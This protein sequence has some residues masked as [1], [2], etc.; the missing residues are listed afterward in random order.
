MD[1]KRIYIFEDD[2]AHATFL[3]NILSKLFP[4]PFT[5]IK[6][7]GKVQDIV[8]LLKEA[9]FPAIFLIADELEDANGL[10]ILKK[11]NQMFV[12]EL[13]FSIIMITRNNQQSSIE[14]LKAGADDFFSKPVLTEMLIARLMNA[15]RFLTEK[16]FIKQKEVQIQHL[17]EENSKNRQKMINLLYQFQN[18][19][20]PIAA[21]VTAEMQKSAPW[22]ASKLTDDL[23][24]IDRV[25]DAAKF[26]YIGKLSLS[27]AMINLPVLTNGFPTNEKMNEVSVYAKDMLSQITNYEDIIEVIEHTYENF[28]G[29]GIPSKIKGWEISL[30]S[31]IL[32]VLIDYEFYLGKNSGKQSKAIDAL[33][34]DAH[35]VYDFQII[36]YLDQ[37]FAYLSFRGKTGNAKEVPMLVSELKPG[38]TLSRNI[39]TSSGLKLV[40]SGTRLNEDTIHKILSINKEDGVI[41]S[42]YIY[43]T[44]L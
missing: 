34:N 41:G 28:D 44:P 43:N 21:K 17:E 27:D 13:K 32:H 38:Q 3:M 14:A 4:P 29:S 33:F 18:S 12:N 1:I 35:R 36:A 42:I 15:K 11:I 8:D 7:A 40:S 10:N 9:V 26:A 5:F 37:Y 22:I 16:D 20:I 30:E 19:K 24:I 23:N 39:F 2:P 25:K 6:V 31:R